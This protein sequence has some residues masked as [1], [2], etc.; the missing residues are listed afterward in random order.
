MS[1]DAA[2]AGSAAPASPSGAGARG[3]GGERKP[4]LP[5]T[6]PN[7]VGQLDKLVELVR[8]H[9]IPI[10]QV[11]VV[12]VA[13]QLR[14]QVEG[15]AIDSGAEALP[16]A[17]GLV[18]DDSRQRLELA[19][20][21]VTD[22]EEAAISPEASAAAALDRLAELEHERV[23][24]QELIR[25]ASEREVETFG[26][27]G[28][29]EDDD[30]DE[31]IAAAPSDD[32]GVSLAVAAGMLLA[33]SKSLPDVEHYP[34]AEVRAAILD[35][36]R[37][38]PVSFREAWGGDIEPRQAIAT[39]VA[40]LEMGRADILELAGRG[41]TLLL[42][43][44]VVLRQAGDDLVVARPGDALPPEVP[45]PR[46]RPSLSCSAASYE[47]WR[48]RERDELGTMLSELHQQLSQLGRALKDMAAAERRK[49]ADGVAAHG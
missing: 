3:E 21:L 7:F 27:G 11:D 46:L 36:I 19:L 40:L 12:A 5:I 47:G 31:A 22:D 28:A 18:R 10:S 37:A 30:G 4:S 32:A 1:D 45:A 6:L 2:R 14:E 42:E 41:G 9:E 25:L 8:R 20:R 49:S 33:A 35:T 24:L 48:G 34:Q 17:A 13:R 16:L 26:G 23:L 39:F 15:G 44:V 38:G 29:R 43:P